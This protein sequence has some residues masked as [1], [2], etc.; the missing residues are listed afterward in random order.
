M[1]NK[2]NK[3]ISPS[4]AEVTQLNWIEQA[5]GQQP[6]EGSRR[7]QEEQGSQVHGHS[8]QQEW[9]ASWKGQPT[10]A[11]ATGDRQR[12]P[13]WRDPPQG[14]RGDAQGSSELS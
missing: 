13:L 12:Q 10:A 9:A 11:A 1:S 7:K 5:A 3:C 4:P 14:R 6:E 2:C 8:G